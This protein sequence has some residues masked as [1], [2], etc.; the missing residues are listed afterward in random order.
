MVIVFLAPGFE[1]V[2]AITVID[3]LR[4]AG[5]ET[6]TAGVGGKFV[7]GAHSIT[8]TADLC[9]EETMPD[10]TLEAVVLPGGMP[11]TSNLAESQTVQTFI[12]YAAE[13]LVPL[14]AICAAPSILGDMGL[15]ADI[16][17]VCYPG[18]ESSLPRFVPDK[19][20]YNHENRVIT[21]RAA[22]A[23]AEFAHCI[24]SVLR[25]DSAAEN[26]RSAMIY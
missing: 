23:A 17:A 15:L 25:G 24:I 1:E 5:I 3:M 19:A 8:V 11:G 10:K 18:F 4:R 12:R 2:E 20:V 6:M 9:A 21:A 16:P 22:G 26:V 13:N 14:C 7:A